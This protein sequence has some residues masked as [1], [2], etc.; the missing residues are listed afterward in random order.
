MLKDRGNL[1]TYTGV[2]S[3]PEGAPTL[4]DMAV[5][6]SRICRYAG[7]GMRWWPVMLH[8][9][10]VCDLLPAPVRVHGLLHD[11]AEC[12]TNDVPKPVKTDAIEELE[13]HLTHK[14]YAALGLT[15]PTQAEYE[16]VKKADR[17]A[18]CGEVYTVG[19]QALQQVY[20]RCPKAE[21]LVMKYLA[22]FPPMEC[23]TPDGRAP[24]EFLRRFRLYSDALKSGK[25]E[26]E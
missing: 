2:I 14:I 18:L 17:D 19:T 8:T 9:F 25:P 22:L 7:G 16:L 12:I 26:L 5:S 21:K 11:G 13:E 23:I 6:L 20:E 3:F 10:V 1:Y 15:W 24:I 4:M